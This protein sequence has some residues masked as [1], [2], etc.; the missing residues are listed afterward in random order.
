MYKIRS[1]QHIG[2]DIIAETWNLAFSDYIVNTNV[3]VDELKAYFKISGV[4]RSMSFGAFYNDKLIGMLIN[5]VDDYNGVLVAY[6]A[7]TGVV[8]EHRSKGV[9]SFLLEHTKDVLKSKGITHYYL[10]VITENKRAYAIYENK[11][12]K[13][14][15]ELSVIEGR[16]DGECDF[17][18]KVLPLNVFQKENL[19]KYAPSFGNRMVALHRN[20]DNYNIAYV[21]CNNRKAS[22]IFSKGG[23]ISQIMYDGSKDSDLLRNILIYLSQQFEMLRISNVPITER[24][25]IDDLLNMGLEILVNQYEMCIEL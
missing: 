7:M 24:E 5:S 1:L 4:D 22:V 14:C 16:I 3:T 20:I 19:S 8:R 13:I 23:G 12:A 2:I 6:D 17:E 25:L 11:N 15:R 21:E 18:V 10:E 9:F